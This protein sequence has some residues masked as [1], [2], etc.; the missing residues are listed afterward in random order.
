VIVRQLS[1]RLALIRTARFP[2]L[3]PA[4]GLPYRAVIGIG[5][6]I[7]DVARRFE[8]LLV[9]LSRASS[10]NVVS[11][12]PILKNPPFG[13]TQQ[14]DF[15]NAV[16]LVETTMQ[17]R[18]L[19]QYLLRVERRFGRVRSFANAPRTL[20]LDILF[21]ERRRLDYPDLTVPHPHWRE[22]ESVVIPLSLLPAG[23]Y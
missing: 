14:Q 23:R 5:G 4:K 22:R 9:F 15:L 2:G 7:G 18:R 6:N 20:D 21:Y 1:S 17:P 12:S 8:H 13:F 16:L 3:F 19:M 11:S 10:I